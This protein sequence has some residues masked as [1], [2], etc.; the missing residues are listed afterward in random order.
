VQVGAD[1]YVYGRVWY[2][3]S[4][5]FNDTIV[6]VKRTGKSERKVGLRSFF[7]DIEPKC[8][9]QIFEQ[10]NT[11]SVLRAP[12]PVLME[13]VTYYELAKTER[14]FDFEREKETILA[15]AYREIE[16]HLPADAKVER[17]WYI[18]KTLDKTTVLDIYYEVE[19]I[20]S[21]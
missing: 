12:L 21:G 8:D 13:Q 9:Y 14:Q 1:G 17:K 4:Y 18:V 15:D 2:T 3:K 10:E 20:I 6:E 16:A 19:Q 7:F 5:T 11:K